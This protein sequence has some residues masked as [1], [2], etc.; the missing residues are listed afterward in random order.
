MTNC[1]ARRDLGQC[2]IPPSLAKGKTKHRG[3]H[4]AQASSM[5]Q[6]RA[7]CQGGGRKSRSRL[8]SLCL[9]CRHSK[10]LVH[11]GI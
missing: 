4:T 3:S 11:D 1:G 10:C 5:C 8:K 9:S 6:G 2:H 7:P